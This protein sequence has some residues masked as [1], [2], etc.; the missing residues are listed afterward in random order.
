MKIDKLE[1]FYK[2]NNKLVFIAIIISK[3]IYRLVFPLIQSIFR[4]LIPIKGDRI[5][6]VSSPDYSDNGRILSEYIM[7][8][9]NYDITWLVDNPE[10]FQYLEMDNLRFIQ[11][12]GKYH[13]YLTLKALYY[14]ASSSKIFYTHSF[15]KLYKKKNGQL[16]INLWHGCGY[17]DNTPGDKE[18]SFDYVLV[19]GEIFI[20][21][22][23]RFFDCT[24]DKILEIGY[25]R[26]DLLRN[27]SEVAKKFIY[28]LP[29]GSIANKII[30]W[31]P[32]FRKSDR[33]V[34]ENEI[35]Y[36]FDL[37]LLSS[38]E[39]M[40]KLNDYCRIHDILII[41]DFAHKK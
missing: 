1:Y 11:E 32:T 8:K 6:F 17:K 18:Y 23:S 15:S 22:K 14:A 10:S 37:P 34:P 21:S 39:E 3:I 29:N 36:N 40:I 20:K 13:N 26:Y 38:K 33:Y 30:I 4:Y 25:P 41:S 9:K 19:P 5:L 24:E 31:M 35:T 12:K 28:D 16:I 7:K 2:R 27:E